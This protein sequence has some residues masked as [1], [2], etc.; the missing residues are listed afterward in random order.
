MRTDEQ[1]WGVLPVI[2]EPEI[3]IGVEFDAKYHGF[4]LSKKMAVE[5]QLPVMKS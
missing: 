3:K 2:R 1:T 5:A 4:I